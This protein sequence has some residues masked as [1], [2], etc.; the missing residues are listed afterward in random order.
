MKLKKKI[1]VFFH[2]DADTGKSTTLKRLAEILCEKS[3]DY[4]EVKSSSR[5]SDKL[6]AARYKD[7]VVVGVGTSGDTSAIVNENLDFFEK[8]ECDVSFTAARYDHKNA[9]YAGD[10]KLQSDMA[11]FVCIDVARN[12]APKKYKQFN[13]HLVREDDLFLYLLAMIK[14][15]KAVPFR[16]G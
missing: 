15:G 11:K 10:K 4:R 16:L 2:G 6:V 7:D 8:N 13:I 12:Q 1:V 9:S 14:K 3:V 5:A